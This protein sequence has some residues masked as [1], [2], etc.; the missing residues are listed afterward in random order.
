[1][2]T[3]AERSQRAATSENKQTEKHQQIKKTFI[4]LTGRAAN[5]HKQVKKRP[6]STDRNKIT[7]R[8]WKLTM[9]LAFWLQF[10]KLVQILWL[11]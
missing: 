5:A 7:P 4:S 6:S 10:D 3:V 9:F 1:M 11:V 8:K 2:F